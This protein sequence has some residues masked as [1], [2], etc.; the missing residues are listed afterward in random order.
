MRGALICAV[1]SLLGA[2][3]SGQAPDDRS[4]RWGRLENPDYP[5]LARQARVE[6]PVIIAVHFT[7]CDVD[8][9]STRVISG[10]PML[11][12]AALDSVRR[13][14]LKCGGFRDSDAMLKFVFQLGA[15]RSDC[16][17]PRAR[18]ST[19]RNEVYVRAAAFCVTPNVA[20]PSRSR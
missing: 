7:G 16:R 11:A 14:T 9:T 2:F 17:S 6:G 10:H 19:H 13:S 8:T 12:D 1:I 4:V 3:G 20:D 5:I 15:E 18:V